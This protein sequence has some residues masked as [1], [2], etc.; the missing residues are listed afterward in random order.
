MENNRKYDIDLIVIGGG[1]GGLASAKQAASLGAKVVL[2]DYVKPSTQGTAWGL[3]GTCVNV[4]CV[5]KKIM[6]YA[7]LVGHSLYDMKE[8][9]WKVGSSGSKGNGEVEHD[10]KKLVSTVTDHVRMLNFRY[11]NG[12]RSKQVTYINALA[13]FIDNHTISYLSDNK[14]PLSVKTMTAENIILAVGGRPV[15]PKDI[16]GAL[17]HAITSDDIF[18]LKRSPG[19]TLSIGSSYISLECSGFLTELGYDVTVAVRSLL[20]RGFDRQCAEKIGSY[21]D[22]TGTKF[23]HH[24]LVKAVEKLPSGKLLVTFY[25]L[26]N[27]AERKEEFDTVFYATGR[28]ADLSGLHLGKAGVTSINDLTGKLVTTNERTNISNIYAIGDIVDNAPELTPVAIKAG[29]LLARRLYGNSD[30]LMNYKMIPT[31]VFTP[32]E[33]GSVGYNEEDAVQ[34]YGEENIEIYLSEFTTLELSAIHR[35]KK[36]KYDEYGELQDLECNCLSKLICLK[37]ENNKV[38]GFHFVGPN[39]GEITQ[40][41]SV[42]T[43]YFIIILLLPSVF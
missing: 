37:N 26:L 7:G 30:K 3:G 1:S 21:M 6:H 23:L 4:G 5:P 18:F 13:S 17:E 2:F 36:A 34:E 14:D 42:L 40:V 16:P 22:D 33:Y 10:W 32:I 12:L 11:K 28:A 9:G 38:I 20:L 15:V 43:S 25:S 8:L 35:H 19:K 29:E 31:T 24:T 39:A 27:K 41:C